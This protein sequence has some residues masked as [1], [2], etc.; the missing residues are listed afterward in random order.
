M[1]GKAPS[2]QGEV[3]TASNGEQY[4]VIGKDRIKITEHFPVN[5]KRIEDLITD[6]IADKIKEKVAKTS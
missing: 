5:G 3:I 2:K 6:L 4:Y 1:I